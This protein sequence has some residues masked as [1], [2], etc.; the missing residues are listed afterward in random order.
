[1]A[2]LSIII[3]SYQNIQIIRDCLDS[4]QKNNDIGDALEVIVSDNSQDMVLYDTIKKEYDWIKIIK[5]ENKGFGAG[6]NRG[7]EISTGKYLLFLN[8]DTILIEP[9]FKFAIEQFEI[10]SDLALFGVQLLDSNKKRNSSF[11]VMDH[12]GIFATL[13]GKWCRATSRFIDGKMFI[14]GADLFVRRETFEQAGRFDENIFMYKEESDL[15]RR[16][17]LSASAKTTRFYKNKHI[18]HLEGGTGDDSRQNKIR[19]MQT[20]WDSD[21]YYAQK[22]GLDLVKVYREKR[23]YQRF[24]LFIYRCLFRKRQVEMQ[25]EIIRLYEVRLQECTRTI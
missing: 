5:N 8:P 6:N 11:F 7:Y 9:L 24:K 22:W 15:I 16:I 1:M 18:V 21:K 23:R 25:K 19:R 2:T 12:Y 14:C 3:V 20:G 17:K 13:W 10:N 4:I